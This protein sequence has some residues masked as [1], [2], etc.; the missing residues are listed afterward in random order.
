MVQTAR[1][2]SITSTVSCDRVLRGLVEVFP[3]IRSLTKPVHVAS[4]KPMKKSRCKMNRT[5]NFIILAFD[6]HNYSFDKLNCATTS[7]LCR[8]RSRNQPRGVGCCR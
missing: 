8:S 7:Y 6:V 2:N 4:Q 3:H 5:S 1:N